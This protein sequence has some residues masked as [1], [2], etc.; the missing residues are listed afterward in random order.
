MKRPPPTLRLALAM[1]GG[2][3]L[4]VWI[5]GAVREI[6]A[7]RREIRGSTRSSAVV[8]LAKVLGY[9]HIDLD[10]V[11]GASAGGLN[12][13]V[14]AAAMASGQPVDTLR[15][16]WL[17]DADLAELV[18]PA[19]TNTHLSVL[20]GDYFLEQLQRR[21]APFARMDG[22]SAVRR[23]DLLLSVTSVVPT[24]VEAVNDPRSPVREQHIDG[25]ICLRHR[26]GDGAD[27]ARFSDFTPDDPAKQKV[28]TCDLALSARATAAF[29]FAFNPVRLSEGRLK[30]RIEF[31]PKRPCPLLLYDGGVVDNMPVGKAAKAIGDAPADGPTERV[32]LYLHPSPDVTDPEARRKERAAR[33]A[34]CL[35]GARPFDVLA[36]A[37][38]SLRGKSLVDDLRALDDHNAA[39]RGLLRQRE[40]LLAGSVRE[41]VAEDRAAP[42]LDAEELTD[43]LLRPWRHLEALLPPPETE[44]VLGRASDDEV[45]RVRGE[46]TGRLRDLAGEADVDSPLP[47]L[48]IGSLRP[49]GPYVRIG[50]LLIEWC[51]RLEAQGVDVGAAKEALYRRREA[52]DRAAARLDEGTLAALSS[53]AQDP[54]ALAARIVDHRRLLVAADLEA[55]R[56]EWVELRACAAELRGRAEGVE[57]TD[58]LARCLASRTSAG[59]PER[60]GMGLDAIDRALL[61]LHRG[62]LTGSLD[63]ITYRTISGTAETPLAKSLDAPDGVGDSPFRFETLRVQDRL[64]D[65]GSKLAGNQFHNFAAFLERHWRA[66]DWMWGQVDAAT[67]LVD[68]LL[69][70]SRLEDRTPDPAGMARRIGAVVEAPFPTDPCVPSA[71]T[72]AAEAEDALRS[73]WTPEVE[74][75]VERELRAA[76]GASEP[77]PVTRWLLL[78][79]RHLEIVVAELSRPAGDNP[80]GRA[81]PE[82]LGAA[83][84][85][86]D[87]A[88]RQLAAQWG[89]V[90]LTAL[91]MRAAFVGWKALFARVTGAP[92]LVRAALAPVI[93]PVIGFVLARR[94]T[95]AAVELFLLGAVLPRLWDNVAGRVVLAVV[96]VAFAGGW[97]FVTRSR[98]VRKDVG[99]LSRLG[100]TIAGVVV[101]ALVCAGCVLVTRTWFEDLLPTFGRGDEGVWPYVAPCVATF[102]GTW[103]MWFW[104]RVPWRA[105]VSLV[106]AA[107]V[108][109]WVA[110]AGHA[111]TVGDWP[112][113][114]VL[115]AFA[116]FWWAV[117]GLALTTTLVGYNVDVG[118]FRPK[119][120]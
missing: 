49:W 102:L 67:T 27:G 86:W 101:T 119:R 40:R 70:P 54:A 32:L 11:S 36:S 52:A 72:F 3:S 64:V 103:I 63:T 58:P 16:V 4:S 23:I 100:W 84:T 30:G 88:P 75:C 92:A 28:A 91:G 15:G 95:L 2:V 62:A 112:A 73:L 87:E 6:E 26:S 83:V 78:L 104:A 90:R 41:L 106:A 57:T 14:L 24:E 93:A 111:G 66:N 20:D 116:S 68:L 118:R 8:E 34:M 53:P 47:T 48:A 108:A 29:P 109:A 45:R 114:G 60:S 80:T 13:V 82:S 7:L 79:R 71:T 51:R 94:R 113:G 65:P 96:A 31:R 33:E 98:L 44:P 19:S 25:M 81:P 38:T 50:S 105:F 22:A 120:R 55:L 61:P 69:D 76:A 1:R 42:E 115:T 5:G 110:L 117:P 39:V 9:D 56:S 17:D 12:G 43:L 74:A 21:L 18:R 46:L 10:V 37:F 99:A 35:S 59:N 77:P 107:T 97:L 85:A 89:G